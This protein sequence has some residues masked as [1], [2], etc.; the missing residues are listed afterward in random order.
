LPVHIPIIWYNINVLVLPEGAAMSVR[1]QDLK[2]KRVD[3]KFAE[4]LVGPF[5]KDDPIIGARHYVDGAN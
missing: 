1:K 3:V 2:E 4:A 5:F